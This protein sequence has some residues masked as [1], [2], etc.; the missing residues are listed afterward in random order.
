MKSERQIE[1]ERVISEFGEPEKQLQYD[2]P[3][4]PPVP[5]AVAGKQG[6]GGAPAA[7]MH[8]IP[9]TSGSR[10]PDAIIVG[11]DQCGAGI[12]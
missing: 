4:P 2:Y 7:G 11:V 6:Q 10:L 1:E 3:V 9:R 8:N 12:L 5:S